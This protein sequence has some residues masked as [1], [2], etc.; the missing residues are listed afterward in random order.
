MDIL[1]NTLPKLREIK[2]C[3]ASFVMAVNDTLNVVNGKW[4]LPIIAALHFG[5]KR[6]K[7]LERDIPKIT[8]R[9][10]SKELRDLEANGIVSRTVY[11][12]I[13]VTVE[14]ELTESGKSFDKVLEVMI[15]WGLQHRKNVFSEN[16]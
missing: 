14:Y 3:P 1:N 16:Q 5:K 15:E 9:M 8:P 2:Q 12:T 13:P 4:K 10:L 6:F 11:D 7:I